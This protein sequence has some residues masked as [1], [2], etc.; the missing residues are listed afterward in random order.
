M[1]LKFLIDVNN[2]SINKRGYEKKEKKLKKD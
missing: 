2:F 1:T